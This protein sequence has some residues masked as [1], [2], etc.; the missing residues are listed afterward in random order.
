MAVI[1]RT[2]K[3]KLSLPIGRADVILKEIGEVYCEK[4]SA[5]RWQNK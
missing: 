5:K 4:C 3:N 2:P 1:G